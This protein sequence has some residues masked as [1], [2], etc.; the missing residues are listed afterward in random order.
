MKERKSDIYYI[1][2]DVL[3]IILYHIIVF[4]V[5]SNKG[6][7]FWICYGF[8][9][10]C[11][12]ISLAFGILIRRTAKNS[13]IGNVGISILVAV[14]IYNIIQLVVGMVLMVL[15]FPICIEIS[16]QSAVLVLFLTV[17]FII[18]PVRQR[19][20]Q[21]HDVQKDKVDFVNTTLFNIEK[22]KYKYN[23]PEVVKFINILYDLIK[24]SDPMSSNKLEDIEKQIT[25][26][27]ADLNISDKLT[28]EIIKEKLL[29]CIEL[30]KER[31]HLCMIFK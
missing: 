16:I 7:S 3:L 26:T 12:V 18:Y 23:E 15:P 28:T 13:E 31:N 29:N 2:A 17:I 27:V 22:L 8:V 6:T 1:I 25:Q 4:F 19:I 9:V 11:F 21:N 24:Y 20:N 5:F 14:F 30:V 10:A